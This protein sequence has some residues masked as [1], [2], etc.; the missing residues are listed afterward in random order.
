M[1]FT[2]AAII[3]YIFVVA[4]ITGIIASFSPVYA[5]TTP[6]TTSLSLTGNKGNDNW[7]ISTVDVNL[8]AFDL[9]SGPASTTYQ[10][11]SSPPQ[12][13][14]YD[15]INNA[16]LNPSF[17]DGWL[18]S[19]NNWQPVSSYLT[20]LLQSSI[21]KVGHRSASILSIANPQYIYWTNYN[22]HISV[23]SGRSY[24]VSAWM[25]TVNVS[26][27][28]GA[29]MEAWALDTTGQNSDVKL[30][31]SQPITWQTDW[32]LRS[33]N[34][35]VP[36]GYDGVYVK[37]GAQ[38]SAGITWYDGVSMHTGNDA[39]TQFIL[40]QNG[41]N[42]LR[43]FST[44]NVGN[45][46]SE[47]I[48]YPIK[49]DTVSPQDWSEFRWE[50]AGN[51]HTYTAYTNVR[52]V[53]S[54]IVPASAQYRWYD[55]SNCNCWSAWTSASSVTRE[56]S[57]ASAAY[58][59]TEFVTIRTHASDMGNSGLHTMPKVQFRIND[60]ASAQ[61]QSPIYSLFGPW[62]TVRGGGD[63]YAH[64]GISGLGPTPDDQYAA[65]GVVIGNGGVFTVKS[66]Y[67]WL[68]QP[69]Q[70]AI[71]PI[72][73]L[74]DVLPQYPQIRSRAQSLQNN[75]L[76]E[77]TGI[78]YYPGNYTIDHNSLSSGF[79]S[80]SHSSIVIIE[81][82]LYINRDFTLHDQSAVAFLVEGDVIYSED[83][84]ESHGFIIAAGDINTNST[85]NESGRDGSLTHH[86]GLIA[87]QDI[88]LSRNLGKNRNDQPA[89][90]IE[91]PV[92]YLTNPVFASLFSGADSTIDWQE[93]KTGN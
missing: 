42:T 62:L 52:D 24:T 31:Q 84:E 80:S 85:N 46:E 92:Q 34:F 32:T 58:G 63:I 75:R 20:L 14:Q 13:N 90:I 51:N 39:V 3:R 56:A 71:M 43:Y 19:I 17:E 86:G 73:T 69:Y 2:R 28:P 67:D 49:I 89:E 48:E 8:R 93:T 59:D 78:Y 1:P 60:V 66:Y 82:D 74:E 81:G 29:W 44:D 36:H 30:T 5:G 88:V 21:S 64:G 47:N 55:D 6:P 15:T 38:T 12:T 22:N 33:M 91:Y 40:Q 79:T 27:A 45:N 50:Q 26:S 87:G 11:N 53:T 10:I 16:V 54:G 83:T 41:L 61:S 23:V 65:Y 37:L 77:T 7:Y 4:L 25:R 18:V 35:T 9:D 70:E 57:G 72:A 76:P 68:V